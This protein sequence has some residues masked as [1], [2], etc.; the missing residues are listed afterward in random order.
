MM[1]SNRLN[2]VLIPLKFIVLIMV[3]TFF[4]TAVYHMA[5][6]VHERQVNENRERLV[7]QVKTKPASFHYN[8]KAVR[9]VYA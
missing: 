8:K 9:Y 7:K 5:H 6:E 4:A 3:A 1:K 2:P